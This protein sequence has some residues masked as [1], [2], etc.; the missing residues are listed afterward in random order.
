ME[1]KGTL[2]AR[3]SANLDRLCEEMT[4][5][6][7]ELV[8][9]V[10][11]AITLRDVQELPLLTL[12]SFL[13]G[14]N[15]VLIGQQATLAVFVAIHEIVARFVSESDSNTIVLKNGAGRTVRIHLASDPDVSIKEEFSGTFRN[16]VAIEIKGGT[17]KS[18]A[19]NRA[20]E[21]EKSHQK[22]RNQ[23]FRDYWTVISM[24]GLDR[25]KLQ[26]ESPTTM[27]WF[28]VAQVLAREGNDWLE[29]RTRIAEAVGVPLD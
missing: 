19:H 9:G 16:K 21:A 2:T 7:S 5:A 12:G 26:S 29:F 25:S 3:Q 17:D 11:P 28:D 20:G 15:N 4:A 23:D 1:V 13:Q 10:A 18:N 22:A 8:R 6:L 14:A 24:S 27:S